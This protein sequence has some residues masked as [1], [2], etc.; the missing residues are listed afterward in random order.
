MTKSIAKVQEERNQ[1]I[2]NF[3]QTLRLGEREVFNRNGEKKHFV[4]WLYAGDLCTL[5][6]PE[7][8]RLPFLKF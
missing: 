7:I 1:P 5:Q 6:K 8:S 4:T 2:E 3:L